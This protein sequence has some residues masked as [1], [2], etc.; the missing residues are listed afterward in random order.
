MKQKAMASVTKSE[1][2]IQLPEH[3]SV[4]EWVEKEI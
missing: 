3:S 2:M 4:A 1:N